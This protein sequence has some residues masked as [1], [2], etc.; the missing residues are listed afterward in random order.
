MFIYLF[1]IVSDVRAITVKFEYPFQNIYSLSDATTSAIKILE[2][3]TIKNPQNYNL[4]FVLGTLY[5][6]IDFKKAKKEFSEVIRLKPDHY[7]SYISLGYL[8]EAD[9]NKEEAISYFKKALRY[10]PNEPIVYNALATVYMRQN[11]MDE[12]KDILEEGIKNINSD[13]SLYFNQTLVLLKFYQGQREQEK[14]IRNMRKAIE[15]SSK[16]EYYFI[17]GVFYLQRQNYEEGRT[18]FKHAMEL[19]PKNIY[20]ILGLATTYKE[21]HQYEKAIEIAKQALAIEPN[22]KEIHEEI[23]EYEEAYKKW[24][25]K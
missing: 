2:S 18:A 23:R 11:R 7:L 4:H 5:M 6:T 3:E 19:N 9:N 15:L 24:R 17:L 21:T 14:I 25:E 10:T 1:I 16:E 8:A 22:N 20:T 12:A 13:E